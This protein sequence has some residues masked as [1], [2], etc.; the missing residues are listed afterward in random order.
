MLII[1]KRLKLLNSFCFS[2][3]QSA[4]LFVRQSYEVLHPI[5]IFN[6]VKMVNDPTIR[7]ELAVSLFPNKDMLIDVA[8]IICSWMVRLL[9]QAVAVTIM[10][11]S[12][13]PR[14]ISLT[15]GKLEE[16]IIFPKLF[17]ATA[18]TSSRTSEDFL[19]T[20]NAISRLSIGLP[21]GIIASFIITRTATQ[22]AW[23]YC[24][25]TIYTRMFILPVLSHSH[26][27]AEYHTN[28]KQVMSLC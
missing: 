23:G 28:R 17:R 8:V 26:I 16:N 21:S 1:E 22:R 9:Q 24:F 2:I 4:M 20:V 6:S 27:I 18:P 14:G 11:Y 13:S 25:T 10:C 12:P 15:F 7:Q 5:V 19:S 3:Q